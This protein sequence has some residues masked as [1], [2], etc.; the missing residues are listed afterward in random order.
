MCC[1]LEVEEERLPGLPVNCVRGKGYGKERGQCHAQWSRGAWC[2]HEPKGEIYRAFVEKA[3]RG[4][5]SKQTDR[6]RRE[7]K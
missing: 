3:G 2:A 4:A 5:P 7:K 6:K 1:A